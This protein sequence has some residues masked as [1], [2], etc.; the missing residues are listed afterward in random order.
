MEHVQSE[1]LPVRVTQ[2]GT[3]K[4]TPGHQFG[5]FVR[6]CHL[7]HYIFSGCGVYSRGGRRY[8]LHAGQGFLIFPDEVTTYRASDE[9]PWHYGW[10]GYTG[11]AA[12]ALT[13]ETGLTKEMPVFTL[14]EPQKARDAIEELA[15]E[16]SRLRLGELSAAGG[17]LRL[18]AL[19]GEL[20]HPAG[21]HEMP[22]ALELYFQKAKWYIE[23]NLFSPVRVSDV[24]AFVGLCRSQ[25]FRV[26]Q[27]AAG[28]SPQEWIQKARIRRAEILMAD[29]KLT[30]RE[31][32]LS[33]GY[34]ELAQMH[35]AFKKQRGMP[36]GRYRKQLITQKE[37]EV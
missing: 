5:P 11:E 23:G 12:A 10:I 6:D 35:T 3:E 7:I 4:C 13:Q 34:S 26:F 20:L 18:L 28:C 27:T 37:R 17:L 24:A 15:L 2:C 30:L 19:T 1:I 32:A 21:I 8:P 22:S 33:S 9:T 29:S 36:P 14:K 16:V 25:L 31:I